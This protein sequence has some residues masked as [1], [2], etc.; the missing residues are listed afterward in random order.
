M[1]KRIIISVTALLLLI[2]NFSL[3]QNYKFHSVFIYNFTKYIQ[4]PASYQNGDFVIAVLGNSG[5]TANLEKMASVKSVGNQKIVVKQVNSVAEAGK[6]HIIFVP[7]SKSGNLDAVLTSYGNKPTLVITE[8][9]GLA[10]KGS[11]IN[12][13]LQAGKW[14]FELNKPAIESSNLRVS[15]ELAKLAIVI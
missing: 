4:W 6:C 13:I 7:N 8:R 11:G 15:N 1:K 2:S 14:K 3:A 12:F 9:A 5:V 10:K